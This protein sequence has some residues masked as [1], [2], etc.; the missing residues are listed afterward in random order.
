MGNLC[1]KSYLVQ[2]RVATRFVPDKEETLPV[3]S[4][5]SARLYP[6]FQSPL[7]ERSVR[8][9]PHSALQLVLIHFLAIVMSRMYVSV[10]CVTYNH[11][12]SIPF[13][14]KSNPRGRFFVPPISF[15]DI[16]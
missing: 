12:L 13:H 7:P 10:A 3:E 9:C 8:V 1:I 14:H 16:C 11:C 4:A 15:P 2:N 6:C 5:T